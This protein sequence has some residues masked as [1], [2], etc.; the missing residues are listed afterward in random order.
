MFD[1]AGLEDF[2][3]SLV[4]LPDCQMKFHGK[5]VEEIQITD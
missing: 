2:P 4:D 3:V 1:S 5:C